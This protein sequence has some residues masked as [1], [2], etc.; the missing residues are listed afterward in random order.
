MRNRYAVTRPQPAEI[1]PLHGA[2]EAFTNGSADNV[3]HL[4]GHEMAS[5]D[6]LPDVEQSISGNP[7]LR[8]M[9]LRLDLRLGEMPTQRLRHPLGLH[10]PCAELKSVVA[11]AVL[12]SNRYHLAALELQHRHRQMHAL[13]GENPGHTHLLRDHTG[14]HDLNPST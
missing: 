2:G 6:L 14:T 9:P 7:K 5:A 8:Q 4:S 13:R 11:V 1:V 3:D 10:G 12:G